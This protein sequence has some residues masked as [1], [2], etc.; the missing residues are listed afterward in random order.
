MGF[1]GSLLV[2]WD[3][4]GMLECGVIGRPFVFRRARLRIDRGGGGD[5]V[6]A[7]GDGGEGEVDGLAGYG[8]LLET[9]LGDG[10]AVDDIL[11]V[12]AEVDL[13]VGG[14][15]ELGGD[16]VVGGV[17]IIGVDAEGVAFSGGYEVWA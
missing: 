6:G 17:R 11:G 8:V 5:R 13:A 16:L 3:L 7:G 10:E 12:E 1:E 15:D 9:H 2:R 4:A 14:E